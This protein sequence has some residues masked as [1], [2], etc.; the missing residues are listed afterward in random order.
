MYTGE[1][2]KRQI[3][4][5]YEPSDDIQTCDV[6]LYSEASN[7]PPPPSHAKKQLSP[8][9]SRSILSLRV[10][11]GGGV[12]NG[13]SD[14][15][16][17]SMDPSAAA[18]WHTHNSELSGFW[19]RAARGACRHGSAVQRRKGPTQSSSNPLKSLQ[20]TAGQSSIVC[21]REFVCVCA[22]AYVCVCEFVRAHVRTPVIHLKMV[23]VCVC[24]CICACLCL[25]VRQMAHTH[26]SHDLRL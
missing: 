25:C 12:V 15:V 4:R 16:S 10:G 13:R 26:T 20:D 22:R 11:G 1:I 8:P 24:S 3:D 19:W 14:Q 23:C 17:L 7:P 5:N 6:Q 21:T 9:P 2:K 18:A